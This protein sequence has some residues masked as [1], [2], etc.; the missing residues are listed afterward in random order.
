[1]ENGVRRWERIEHP[2][3]GRTALSERRQTVVAIPGRGVGIGWGRNAGWGFAGTLYVWQTRL[4][5]PI[6]RR[7]ATPILHALPVA[8]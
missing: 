3:E 7:D 5:W 4:L 6:H 2:R 8:A 1:M